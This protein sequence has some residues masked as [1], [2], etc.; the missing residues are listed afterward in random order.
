M[1]GADKNKGVSVTIRQVRIYLAVALSS[2]SII[3][4]WGDKTRKFPACEL[5]AL[6][7]Q[8]SIN[9]RSESGFSARV[10]APCQSRGTNRQRSK[11]LNVFLLR[12][13]ESWARQEKMGVKKRDQLVECG[14]L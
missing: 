10:R 12:G 3:N 4:V 8:K 13:E 1:R 9:E 11:L 5:R 14:T 2:S 6:R 7:H